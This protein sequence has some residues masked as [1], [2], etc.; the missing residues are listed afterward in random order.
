MFDAHRLPKAKF[1][2]SGARDLPWP[3]CC[4]AGA[5]PRGPEGLA[6]WIGDERIQGA[7]P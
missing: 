5:W 1:S 6:A 2:P 7:A 3:Q 4:A